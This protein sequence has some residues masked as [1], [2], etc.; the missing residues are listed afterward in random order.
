MGIESRDYIRDTDHG[1]S[2]WER[3]RGWS[4]VTWIIVINVVVFVMQL[5]FARQG[6]SQA[7]WLK[8]ELVLQGQ[9]WRLLTSAFLHSD[10]DVFH[11]LFNMYVLHQF[12]REVETLKGSKEFTVFYLTAALL[13]GVA[14]VLWGLVL[15]DLTP[16]VGA[17]GAVSAVVIVFAMFWPNRQVLMFLFIPMK[18]RTLAI[19]VVLY[20]LYPMVKQ[21]SGGAVNDGIG[22]SAHLAGYVFAFIYVRQNWNLSSWLPGMSGWAG[23]LRNPLRRRPQLRVHRPDSEAEIPIDDFAF[24]DRVDALL[25][26]IAEQG[27][28]SLTPEERELLA[29]ASRRAR[30]RLSR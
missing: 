7:L 26:K 19:L 27:E 25:A 10:Q 13:S 21:I 17:S 29:E 11:I 6:L 15:R 5:M 2:N 22:H 12:G 20:D 30:N 8:P 1:P 4:A 28:A 3:A 14:F 9:V 23:R 24:N 16:A 18:I